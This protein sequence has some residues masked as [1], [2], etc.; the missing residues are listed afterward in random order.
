MKFVLLSLQKAK[1]NHPILLL[2]CILSSG[3][4]SLVQTRLKMPLTTVS[5]DFSSVEKLL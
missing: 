2:D 3:I 5:V 1:V 4:V